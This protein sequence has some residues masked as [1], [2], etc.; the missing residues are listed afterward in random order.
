MNEALNL[1]VGQTVKVTF[2]ANSAERVSDQGEK[3]TLEGVVVKEATF[4]ERAQQYVVTLQTEK[5]YRS[6]PCHT[7][8]SLTVLS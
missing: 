8:T 3:K 4:G 7:V 5:G 6:F 1:S 2:F